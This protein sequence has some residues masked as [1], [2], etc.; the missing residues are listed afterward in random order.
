[1]PELWS[2]WWQSP[3]GVLALQVIAVF[4]PNSKTKH[5][6]DSREKPVTKALIHPPDDLKSCRYEQGSDPDWASA[7]SRIS[8]NPIR[9]RDERSYRTSWSASIRRANRS[10]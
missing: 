10:R 8:S 2:D 3:R 9:L 4:P 5:G 6:Y 1:M 7:G